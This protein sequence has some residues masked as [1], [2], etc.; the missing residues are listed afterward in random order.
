MPVV[1]DMTTLRLNAK[2]SHFDSEVLPTEP[3]ERP[4]WLLELAETYPDYTFDVVGEANTDNNYAADF[5]AAAERMPNVVVHGKVPRHR[6]AE[7]YRSADVLCCTSEFEGFPA[8]FLEAWSFGLPTVSTVDP[9]GFISARNAGVAVT[10]L[11][12]MR[13]AI[14]PE[15]LAESRRQWSERA[16]E[17]YLREFSP[18]ACL[19]RFNDVLRQVA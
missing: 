11:D 8:T 4:H 17:L 2:V 5:R 1:L 12:D 16:R 19:E 18:D 15:R 7:F 9:G 3:H 6:I 10:S 13:A 14:S